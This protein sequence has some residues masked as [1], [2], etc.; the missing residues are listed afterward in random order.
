MTFVGKQRLDNESAI[1]PPGRST[2]RQC[3]AISAWG[4]QVG[5]RKGEDARSSTAGT[6]LVQCFVCTQ[7]SAGPAGL[8]EH[9]ARVGLPTIRGD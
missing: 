2:L 4:R 7:R 1:V 3:N 5:G 8:G 6:M 9:G